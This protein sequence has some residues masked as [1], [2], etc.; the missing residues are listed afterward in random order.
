MKKHGLIDALQGLQDDKYDLVVLNMPP[1]SGKLISDDT[2]VLTKN[3]WKT[4][5]NLCVGDYVLNDKGN[6]VLVVCVSPKVYA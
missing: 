3:G 4:H 1:R 2:P 6:F 5:G